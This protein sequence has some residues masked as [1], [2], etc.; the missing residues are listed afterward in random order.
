V[1]GMQFK[2]EVGQRV[3]YQPEC[4]GVLYKPSWVKI[5]DRTIEPA[6]GK[7]YRIRHQDGTGG[8]FVPEAKLAAVRPTE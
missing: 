1:A 2:F 8:G 5:T 4:Y 6:L 3:W 7:T